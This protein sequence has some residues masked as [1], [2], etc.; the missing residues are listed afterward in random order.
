MK[1]T[2]D[3]VSKQKPKELQTGYKIE[4]QAAELYNRNVFLKFQF[5]LKM[6]E[7]LKYKE[8]EDG[9]C[10]E[11]WHKS[12]IVHQL[13]TNR[14]YIVLTDLTKGKEEF[15]CICAK[16]SKD[17]ILC[18][19]ILKVIVEEEIDEMPDK[20][21]IDRWR[22]KESKLISK[23]LEET[24]ATNELFRFNVLSRKAALLTSKGSK[25]EELMN[26]LD[27]EFD[28]IDQEID[29]IKQAI[30]EEQDDSTH[31][32]EEHNEESLH[33]EDLERIKNKG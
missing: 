15:S 3:N 9:K 23:Q 12:N 20:Y 17:G 31:D 13:Q 24:P 26:Y 4:L 1:N 25:S 18:C 28:R 16:F 14:K 10:L 5:Q 29:L 21:F 32:Q 19:H 2:E 8:I 27:E 11:V 22:K 30:E 33:L 6:T 7:G